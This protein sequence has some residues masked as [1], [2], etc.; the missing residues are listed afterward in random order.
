LRKLAEEDK[1]LE[2]GLQRQA[3]RVA[4]ERLQATRI[5]LAAAAG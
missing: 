3:A 4:M 5:Q 1:M 2:C